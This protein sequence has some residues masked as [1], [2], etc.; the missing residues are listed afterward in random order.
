M[1]ALLGFDLALVLTS[2]VGP[3]FFA[4][5]MEMSCMLEAWSFLCYVMS[6]QLKYHAS[7]RGDSDL[8]FLNSD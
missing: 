8:M 6:S 1:F 4:F 2:L 5:K 7:L 3:T